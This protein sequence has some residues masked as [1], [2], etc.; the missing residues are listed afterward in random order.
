L[1]GKKEKKIG[2]IGLGLMGRPMASNL[3]KNGYDVTVY[4]RSAKAVQEL[5]SAGA[6][7][8]KSPKEVA[9]KSDIVIDMVTDAP[10]VEQV[11]LGPNGVIEGAREGLVVID[12]STNS[13]GTASEVAGMLAKKKIKFL[14]APVSGG[15]KGAREGT[16]AIMVG[17][18]KSV[19]DACLPVFE[20]MGKSIFYMGETG[21]GQATKLC[22]QVTVSIHTLATSEALL[23]G[24]AF[25][26]KL[27]DLIK[28]VGSGAGGSWNFVN[29]G[30]KIARKD[31]EPGFKAAHL[32]KDLKAILRMAEKENLMLPGSAALYELFSGVVADKKGEKGTQVLAAFLEKISSHEIG[33]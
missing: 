16:L 10:D 13:P 4:N 3:M 2:F 30:P 5:V 17:G 29:L 11:L 26:L 6:K 21:S 33:G 25:G 24:S 28:V 15:D 12:M 8:G 18:E 22:N 14:D 20:A 19:F 23:L 31:Y 1:S 27:D 7:E 32:Y 9:E